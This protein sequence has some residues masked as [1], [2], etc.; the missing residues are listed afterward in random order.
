MN[1]YW[2]NPQVWNWFVNKPPNEILQ[3]WVI[4]SEKINFI[5]TLPVL[6]AGCGSGRNSIPFLNEGITVNAFDPNKCAILHLERMHSHKPLYTKIAK[7]QDRPFLHQKHSLSIFDGV[8]H[9]LLSDN[10]ILEGLQYA[11]NTISIGGL[12]FVSVFTSDVV[13]ERCVETQANLFLTNAGIMMY[14]LQSVIWNELV[15][16][17]GFKI[18]KLQKSNFRLDVGLRSNVTYLLRKENE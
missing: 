7:I 15:E 17:A 13:P 11:H 9:Q 18:L 12:C 4:K 10:E 14:L 1:K 2:N 6:D 8:F 16:N 3:S 5:K